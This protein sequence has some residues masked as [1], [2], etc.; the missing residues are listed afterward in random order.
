MLIT[1]SSHFEPEADVARVLILEN[2]PCR[3]RPDQNVTISNVAG[4]SCEPATLSGG[5]FAADNH[6]HENAVAAP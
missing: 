1:S 4:V 5:L 6:H 2:S 3:P